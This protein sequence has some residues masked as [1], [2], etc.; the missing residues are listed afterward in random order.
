[1]AN[2]AIVI[3]INEYWQPAASLRGAVADALNMVAWLTS[4]EGGNVPPRNLYLLT[5]PSPPQLD[6][7]PPLGVNVRNAEY[8]TLVQTGVNLINKSGG[9]GEQFFF[10]FSGHGMVNNTFGGE[11]SLAFSDFSP[12]SPHKSVTIASIREYFGNTAFTEQFFFFDAC[13]NRL[14]WRR[15]FKVSE[16]PFPGE[17]DPARLQKVSQCVL[18]ATSPLLRAVEMNERGAFTEILLEG[19]A[20]AGKAKIY[21]KD[22]DEYVVRV[23][24]LFAYVDEE[25]RKKEILVTAPPDPPLYQRVYP[26]LKNVPVPPTLTRIPIDAVQP[27]TLQIFIEPD[28]VWT[29]TDVT[30]TVTSE[31]NDYDQEIAPVKGVPVPLPPVILPKAYTV[32]AEAY[33]Y[34]PEKRRWPIDLYEPQTRMLKLNPL[35]MTGG[36]GTSSSLGASSGG[37]GSTRGVGGLGDESG[38]EIRRGMPIPELAP[39]RPS[40]GG[41]GGGI[42][43][44]TRGGFRGMRGAAATATLT[45]KSSDPLAPIEIYDNKGELKA[46]GLGT[47]IAENLEPDFYRAQLVTPEG[48]IAEE[49]V[50]LSPGESEEVSL[51]APSLPNTGLFKE[52]VAR[53]NF[54]K[55]DEDQ[56]LRFSEAVGP[57][58]TPQLTTVLALAGSVVVRQ[59]GWGPNTTQLGLPSFHELTSPNAAHGL[60]VICADE[61]SHIEGADNYLSQ[62]SVHFWKQNGDAQ[63]R[64]HTERE[65]LLRSREFVGIADFASE[66]EPGAYVLEL[67]VPERPPVYFSFA[68]LPERLTLVVLHRRADGSIRILSFC[69]ST[70]PPKESALDVA[71]QLRRL[72]LLQRFYIADRVDG[73]HALR[74]AIELLH[75]KWIDPL[76]G[77]LGGYTMLKLG[78]GKELETAVSN[79]KRLYDQ[80]PDTHVLAAEYHLSHEANDREAE[81]RRAYIAALDRGLPVFAEGLLR[82]ASNIERFSISHTR[83]EE[84]KRVFKNRAK[85]LLWTAWT[86]QEDAATAIPDE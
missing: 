26:E 58:A 59:Y 85:N 74:N 68:I 53:T 4:Q 28:G 79:M 17:E 11:S 49:L 7:P 69:P 1:M 23:D 32:R 30:V 55:S 56:T 14:D 16:F 12:T 43:G 64:P 81:A 24:R 86:A 70:Q 35:E 84:V 82:L 38:S 63:R 80:L 77:C 8:D 40:A 66:A 20:G 29:Q 15:P 34:R 42:F 54:Y 3:G 45:A 5:S 44:E 37:G 78:Q 71:T 2:W 39:D 46:E 27:V 61:A 47:V 50:D 10:Y 67:T 73:R 60:R 62:V 22:A 41:R 52:I 72:E 51:D 25:V 9:K 65:Q 57:M 33:G 18:S 31:D 13:R 6:S 83:A 19:L 75:A 48:R 36:G 76:A 21:D